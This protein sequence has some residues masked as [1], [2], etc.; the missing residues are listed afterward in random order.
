MKIEF[1]P[2]LWAGAVGYICTYIHIKKLSFLRLYF[3]FSR[4][5]MSTKDCCFALLIFISWLKKEEFPCYA[6]ITGQTISAHRHIEPPPP[7]PRRAHECHHAPRLFAPWPL[8]KGQ[9]RSS[10]PQRLCSASLLVI[11]SCPSSVCLIP[12]MKYL[13]RCSAGASC[14]PLHLAGGNSEVPGEWISQVHSVG[15]SGKT[16]IS[17]KSFISQQEVPELGLQ[18]THAITSLCAST[19]PN[20]DCPM[21]HTFFF[22]TQIKT[23]S[24]VNPLKFNGE[25]IFLAPEHCGIHPHKSGFWC[26]GVAIKAWLKW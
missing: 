16:E 13:A 3:Y 12:V 17:S 11:K 25:S 14:H 4:L 19:P 10:V 5:C 21:S 26:R 8:P 6:A 23:K 18:S 15:G 2:Q 1:V 9:R 24:S 20:T 22:R 7:E